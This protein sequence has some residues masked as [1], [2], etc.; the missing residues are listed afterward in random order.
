MKLIAKLTMFFLFLLFNQKMIANCGSSPIPASCTPNTLT[1]CC[2]FGITNFT[3]NTINNTTN[4]GIDGYTD[5]SC[6]QT[7]V[8]EGQ[9]Y[10]LS[11]QT[12]ASSTQNYAAWIDFNNDGVFNDVTE[13]VFTASSQMNTSGN[14]TIPAG[15]VLNTPLRLRVSSDY[16]LNAAPMPCVDLGFGQAEDY[17]VVITSNPN[18]PISIFSGSPTTTC[19]GMVCFTD[20]SLNIPTGWLWNFGDGNT[21]FQQNPCY[22]Y[23]SDGVYTVTLTVT[24]ANG[25]N[26]DSIVN[27][28]TVNTTGQ[29]MVASCTPT[30][31]AYCC[32]YGI[33][34][35][36]FNT[37]SNLTVD[38]IEG[39]QDFSCANS[40][41]VT[42][43]N[44]YSL[45]VTTGVSNPQD[46]R[47][48]IDF[49]NDGI[50]NNTNELIMDIQ[51]AF[52][53]TLNI[54]IPSGAVLNTPLRMRVSSDVIGVT[55]AACDNNDFGQ[56]EDYGIII[57]SPNAIEE[58]DITEN[59]FLVYPN[60]ARN[61]IKIEKLFNNIKVK[62]IAVYNFTG[63]LL[64][65]FSQIQNEK[66]I[67]VDISNYTK[68]FY[69]LM[70]ETESKVIIKKFNIY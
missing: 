22:T 43:G 64:L 4:D 19:D 8:L 47:V 53:P 24:N 3:F 20:Q 66:V 28:I 31:T 60:P 62:S 51:S 70:I 29:V 18:P 32:G 26:V 61:D 38:G 23:A 50:F 5:S 42:E 58:I 35:V 30:T 12:S 41:T 33:Y 17:A 54:T 44:S 9:T 15:A 49:N 45:T 11:I 25:A 21:S 63:Q 39:Y 67:T 2:G 46:T 59:N 56:T 68:G 6:V 7:T 16:D 13:R 55:Q 27:Y 34:Q 52:N 40:T 65:K 37:I 10:L 36:D 14:V 57:I 48:W 1:Y 69:F